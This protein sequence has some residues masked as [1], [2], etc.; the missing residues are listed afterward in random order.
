MLPGGAQLPAAI[1]T[2]RVI[3]RLYRRLLFASERLEEASVHVTQERY[4]EAIHPEHRL[5]GV[6]AMVV[7]GQRRGKHQISWTYVGH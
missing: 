5:V 6:M 1:A 7:P 4:I 2:L 3:N